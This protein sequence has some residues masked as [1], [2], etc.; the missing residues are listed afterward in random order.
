MRAFIT[1]RLYALI[2]ENNAMG[3]RLSSVFSGTKKPSDAE[4]NS[5]QDAEAWPKAI[6]CAL[7]HPNSTDPQL[8]NL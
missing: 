2:E 4:A 5:S 8:R 7:E 1:Q 3:N 6:K